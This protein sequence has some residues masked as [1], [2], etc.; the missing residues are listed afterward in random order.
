MM[1]RHRFKQTT[2]IGGGF[3]GDEGKGKIITALIELFQPRYVVRYQGGSNAGHTL[4]VAGREF[5]AHL[6]PS[7]VLQPGTINVIG[8]GVALNVGKLMTEVAELLELVDLHPELRISKYAQLV[9][10][11]HLTLDA[12]QETAR[13]SESIGT[14]K[15]GIGPFY[16]TVA[17]RTGIQVGSLNNPTHL[18]KQVRRTVEY[19][20]ARLK[21]INAEPISED[22]VMEEL[23]GVK[24]W[25]Q[26]FVCDVE[27]TL[28]TAQALG[29]S[30]LFEAQ[31][32][33][34][35]DVVYGQ[36]PNVTSSHP[37]LRHIGTVTGIEPEDR[38]MVLK[39]YSSMVGT[40]VLGTAIESDE[41]TEILRTKGGNK[42][43]YGA[44]TGRARD[45]AWIDLPAAKLGVRYHGATEVALTCLDVW[46]DIGI[47]ELR[48][49][50]DYTLNGKSLGRYPDAWEVEEAKPVYETHPGW[51][52]SRAEMNEIRSFEDLPK[53]AQSYVRRIE[54]YL[55]IPVGLV[56]VGP[57]ADQTIDLLSDVPVVFQ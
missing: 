7:G 27:E 35:R 44:T 49:C 12:G 5:K 23:D 2:G 33:V 26:P 1:R 15:Q 4:V 45:L 9:L 3:A 41:L 52:M 37:S 10:P 46:G 36:H 38:I 19:A 20:N 56:S 28:A 42:G 14:T 16:E 24:T 39:A 8:T 29:E 54:E 30:M 6:L 22:Q 34:I 57:A 40:G 55:R 18:R 21:T 13:G 48:I 43:E 17:A 25:I 53:E 11:Y 50:I 47:P 51:N 31:L 32:G